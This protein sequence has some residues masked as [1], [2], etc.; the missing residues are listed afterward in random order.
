M[1]LRITQDEGPKIVTLKL[2]GKLTGASACELDRIWKSVAD[3]VGSKA[4]ILD[5]RGVTHLDPQGRQI[6]SEIHDASGAHFVADNP[7]TKYFAEQAQLKNM[8]DETEEK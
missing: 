7:M 8:K 3:T 1:T 2:E 5:I 6:L 4:L